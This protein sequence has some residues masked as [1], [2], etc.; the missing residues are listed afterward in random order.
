MIEDIVI[1]EVIED[2]S[3]VDLNGNIMEENSYK[4]F[5]IEVQ[6]EKGKPSLKWKVRITPFYPVKVD[7]S[8]SIHFFNT[9]LIEYP[10]IM[11]SGFL[12][13]HTPKVENS[14]EQFKID[15]NS[16]TL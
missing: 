13:L 8:E 16:A 10:H 15:L 5:S 7:N 14:K 1:K 9:S 3:F 12:C 4:K 6:T 2:L 11:R